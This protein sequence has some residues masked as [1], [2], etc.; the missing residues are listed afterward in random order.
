MHLTLIPHRT[1]FGKDE[2]ITD[3]FLVQADNFWQ[4]KIVPLEGFG[5]KPN[6]L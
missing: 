2:P 4:Q 5:P 1:T 3:T 6:F